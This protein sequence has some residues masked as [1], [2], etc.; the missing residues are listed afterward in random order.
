MDKI[1]I[2]REKIIDIFNSSGKES[3]IYIYENCDTLL[4]EF[5]DEEYE[6]KLYNF[7]LKTNDYDDYIMKKGHVISKESLNNKMKKIELIQNINCLK[8][9]IK[10]LNLAFEND[11]FKGYT[12]KREHLKSINIYSKK[13]IKL[14]WLKN[15]KE[16]IIELNKNNIYIGDYNESNFLTDENYNIKICDLDN[17]RINDLDFDTKH[18][19]ISKFEINCNKKEYIDSYCFNLFTIAFL[20]RICNDPFYILNSKLPGVLKNKENYEIFESMK[21]LDNTYQYKFL[22]D[23]IK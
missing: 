19:F 16:K 2:K 11:M 13:K 23:N 6:K 17:L 12:M 3:I 14:L 15:I 8:N 18:N 4:K 9:E 21:Y 7:Y 10:V 22:I 5:R 20:L 1:N